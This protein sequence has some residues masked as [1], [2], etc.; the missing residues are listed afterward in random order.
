MMGTYDW[1]RLAPLSCGKYVTSSFFL[2]LIQDSSRIFQGK[3]SHIQLPTVHGWREK[4]VCL[5]L[6]KEDEKDFNFCNLHPCFP[7]AAVAGLYPLP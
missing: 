5:F 3:A 1:L 6:Q 2:K 4:C 7:L